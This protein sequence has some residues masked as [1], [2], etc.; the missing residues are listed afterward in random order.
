MSN[1]HNIY[2]IQIM[3]TGI[4]SRPIYTCWHATTVYIMHID[5][6]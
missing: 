3:Y 2:D 4:Q 5:N 6:M 1:V